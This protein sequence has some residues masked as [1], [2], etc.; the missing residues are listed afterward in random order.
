MMK[1]NTPH[2]LRMMSALSEGMQ[3]VDVSTS[4]QCCSALDHFATYYFNNRHKE[5]PAIL[6]MNAH[7]AAQPELF[8]RMLQ[9]L[10]NMILFE[11]CSNQ[12]SVSRPLLGMIVLNDKVYI[13]LALF[14]LVLLIFACS[15]SSSLNSN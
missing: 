4:T 13:Y 3:S 10:L 12:W 2:F 7:L 1:L 11:D 8:P 6:A 14:Y 9:I 5:L 15:I